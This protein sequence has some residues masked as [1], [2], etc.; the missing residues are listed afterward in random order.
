MIEQVQICKN[1]SGFI[2]KQMLLIQPPVVQGLAVDG[3]SDTWQDLLALLDAVAQ[4]HHHRHINYLY[5][6]EV[7]ER[8][9]GTDFLTAPTKLGLKEIIF[10][11]MDG[12]ESKVTTVLYQQGQL[13]K[14][15]RC[16]RWMTRFSL[17]N[18]YICEMKRLACICVNFEGTVMVRCH[19]T[20]TV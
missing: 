1:V 11:T 20:I 19:T 15:I 13:F 14:S 5:H 2:I 16:R 10:G 3:I 18:L 12:I 7:E 9:I 6:L 8:F 4:A 17:L